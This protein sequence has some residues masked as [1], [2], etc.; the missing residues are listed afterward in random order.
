[1]RLSVEEITRMTGARGRA[2]PEVVEGYSIDSRTLRPGEMFFAVR[3]ERDGHA[4]VDA[5]L[6]A[7]AAAAVAS[8]GPLRRQERLLL[9][10]DPKTALQQLA[11]RARESW[12][13][14]VVAVTGS[15]GKTTTKEIAAALLGTRFRVARSEGNLNNDLGLPLSL[16]RM[17]ESAEVAVLEMGMSHPGELRLLASIARPDV[18]VVTNVS[19]AHLEFFPSQD[20]IAMAKRELIESLPAAGT[21][22]LNAD[23]E[24]VREFAA[25]HPGPVVRFGIEAPAEV[26][27]SE[28][29]SLGLEGTRFRL[30]DGGP[31]FE[32]PLAGRHNL[33]NVLAGLAAG[34]ALGIAPEEMREA[35]AAL[36]PQRMRGE[37]L[38]V[39]GARVI[40]DCYNSN[41]RAAESMLELLAATPAKRRVA[42]L[43]EM[44]EL[45]EASES[46]HRH[47][48]RKAAEAGIDIVIGVSGM[49]RALAEQANGTFFDDAP[50]AGQF[51]RGALQPGDVVLLKASRGVRLEQ[52]MAALKTEN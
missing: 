19:A 2:G 5:A 6:D 27:A 36:R 24:R 47:V 11:A 22:V 4:F 46:L 42:V 9:V 35:V 33:Y 41:P 20:E 8:R 39:G 15:N 17:D 25:A 7:G 23:D 40:N 13:G 26:R 18:G 38:E 21:A 34:V 16:L 45:G 50:A 10:P 12:G 44:L 30:A 3:G 49:A 1:M 28:V 37:V 14:K 52:A 32:A 29:E 31:V 48:G 51:L 43:G